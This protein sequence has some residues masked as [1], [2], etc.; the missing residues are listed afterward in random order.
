MWSNCLSLSH[1][2]K[3]IFQETPMSS[4]VMGY[5]GAVTSA[6]SIAVSLNIK[7]TTGPVIK[8]WNETV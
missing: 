8:L 5:V 4:F 7:C 2:S 1:L 6:C 3:K